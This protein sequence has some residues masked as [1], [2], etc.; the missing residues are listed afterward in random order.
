MPKIGT[1]LSAMRTNH[2]GRVRNRSRI[3]RAVR[4]KD[5]IRLERE[6]LFRRRLRRNDRDAALVFGE[7]A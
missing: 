5:A 1:P 7:Q 3:A 2:C 6:R 4:E